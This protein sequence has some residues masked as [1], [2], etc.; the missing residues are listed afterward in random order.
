M[1]LREQARWWIGHAAVLGA[2]AVGSVA[3]AARLPDRASIVDTPARAQFSADADETRVT[4]RAAPDLCLAFSLPR[5]W[6]A[7]PGG[8]EIR[9]QD[10]SSDAELTLSLRPIAELQHV[11]EADL[12]RRDA[13]LLQRDYEALLGRPAQSV[14][15]T[16]TAFG[17]AR[18]SATWIDASL[19]S[20]S[21]QLTIETLIVPVSGDRVLELS[22]SNVD[23]R[24][25]H[26]AIV[27][28]L[29]SG[30]T[31]QGAVACSS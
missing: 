5:E 2:M 29:L 24:P 12:M 31:V 9:L 1:M 25:T 7:Q 13:V 23:A 18:W 26:E 27:K 28:T 19:P 3:H 10:A 11:A 21:R 17:A 8:P 20:A 15:L 16:G 6:R 4:A 22:L 30:L 14:S